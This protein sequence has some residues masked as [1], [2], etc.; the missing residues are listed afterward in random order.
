MVI[1]LAA[2]DRNNR[3]IKKQSHQHEEISLH[4]KP[5]LFSMLHGA[6][7]TGD[8]NKLQQLLKSSYFDPNS[9]DLKDRYGRSPLIFSVL[10]NHHECTEILLKV[11]LHK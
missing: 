3:Q 5:P 11:R 9:V 8:Y 4:A 6:A 10:G 1:F 2:A 7:I